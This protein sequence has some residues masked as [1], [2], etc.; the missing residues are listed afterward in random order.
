MLQYLGFVAMPPPQEPHAQIQGG[1]PGFYKV[2]LTLSRPGKPLMP[3]AQVAFFENM[4]GD[5]HLAIAQPAYH[6][7]WLPPN[8]PVANIILQAQTEDGFFDLIGKPNT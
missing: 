2:V 8:D 1:D 3:E 6:P 5:S 4:Q 7:P